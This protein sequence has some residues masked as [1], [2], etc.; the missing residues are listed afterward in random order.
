MN[1]KNLE[2]I[3]CR[4]LCVHRGRKLSG[5]RGNG[6]TAHGAGFLLGGGDGGGKS[7]KIRLCECSIIL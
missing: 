4:I 3:C 5:H 1:L 7:S 6:V 2:A